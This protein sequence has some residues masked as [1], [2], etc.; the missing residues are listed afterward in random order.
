MQALK[1][2]LNISSKND[3]FERIDFML[4]E[5]HAENVKGFDHPEDIAEMKKVYC[6][7]YFPIKNLLTAESLYFYLDKNNRIRYKRSDKYKNP[8]FLEE[9]RKEIAEMFPL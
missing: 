9:L 6:D 3:K 5:Y 1:K 4:F 7:N 8:Y 2:Q